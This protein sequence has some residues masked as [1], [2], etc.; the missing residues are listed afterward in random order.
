[1]R[2]YLPAYELIERN[3]LAEV[4]AL[5]AAEPGVWRPFAGGT[6]LMVQFEMG[7]LAHKKFLS[8]WNLDELRG[9]EERVHACRRWLRIGALET[10]DLIQAHAEVQRSFPGL[11]ASSRET[12]AAAIQNRGT[13]GGNLANASPAADSSPNLLVYGAEIEIDSQRGQRRLPYAD[14]HQGYK[15]TALAPDELIAAVW[16]PLRET[17]VANERHYYRKIGT[18]KAQAISKVALSA[19]AHVAGARIQEARFALASVADRPLRA[20]HVEALLVGAPLP[21]TPA[22]LAQARAALARDI[23][24]QDDIR[25]TSA[26]RLRVAGNL[27]DEFLRSL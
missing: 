11:A 21:V 1:M 13:L 16:L 24:P 3:T 12:G 19:W 22:L 14:F 6:D 7:R 5:L 15:K 26:Y 18:R 25:S 17:Q 8:I 27:V 9:I 10:Y 23:A 20:P 4:L 2:A